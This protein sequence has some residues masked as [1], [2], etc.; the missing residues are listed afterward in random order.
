MAEFRK[1]AKTG[2]IPLNKMKVFEVGHDRVLIC[3]VD[4]T[5]H[6]VADECTHDGAPISTGR[7]F[8]G[9]VVC[10]RHGARFNVNDGSVAAPPAIVPI[11]TFEVK[12]DGDDILVALD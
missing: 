6:A 3:N 1:V 7:L 12:V 2:D 4:G 10:P 9:Q 8:K 11:D 5:F